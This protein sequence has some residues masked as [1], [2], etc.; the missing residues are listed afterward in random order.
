MHTYHIVG[1]LEPRRQLVVE[2]IDGSDRHE[3]SPP[4]RT[5]ILRSTHPWALQPSMERES[6]HEVI[7]AR[8][9]T[10]EADACNADEACFLRNDLDVAEGP[11]DVNK[12]SCKLDDRRIGAGEEG[13]EREP[14]A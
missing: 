1:L 11:Q 5:I 2:I 10:G 8:R 3:V 4:L 12:S 9:E 14:S 13:L 6:R 7:L